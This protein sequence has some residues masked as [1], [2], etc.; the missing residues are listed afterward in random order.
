MRRSACLQ[1]RAPKTS[2]GRR[3]EPGRFRFAGLQ[4][5][6]ARA[7]LT[8]FCGPL[9]DI[10]HLIATC[11]VSAGGVDLYID[12]RPRA[13]AAYDPAFATLAEYPDPETREAFAESSNRKDYAA[14]FF[15]EEAEAW[16]AAL[17]ALDGATPAAPTGP[18]SSR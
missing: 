6:G 10:P 14:A 5:E 18:A 8:A 13:D 17:L 1:A 2:G 12:W 3:Y 9:T 16:K 4:V 7:G 11:G 15:T